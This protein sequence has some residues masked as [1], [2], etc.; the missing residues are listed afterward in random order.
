MLYTI[1]QTAAKTGLTDHAIRFYDREGLLPLLERTDSGIR[2]FSDADIDWLG[3][4]CCLKNS[5][6]PINKI[7]EFMNLCLQGEKTCED[8]KE[9]LLEHKGHILQQMELLQDSLST[10]NYKLEHYKEVGVFH[11]DR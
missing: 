7:K 2:K 5:G 9:I 10:V 11:I 8:R 1:K 4:I 6:M 3:L